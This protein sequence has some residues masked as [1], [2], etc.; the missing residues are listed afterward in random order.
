MMAVMFMKQRSS[1]QLVRQTC[2]PG[3]LAGIRVG[4]ARYLRHAGFA[5]ATRHECPEIP[6]V[7]TVVGRTWWGEDLN[8]YHIRAF[9]RPT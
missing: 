7:F 5:M 6:L 2:R 9:D 4:E 1:G 8:G 3:P